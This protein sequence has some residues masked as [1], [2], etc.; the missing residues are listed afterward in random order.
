MVYFFMQ[1]LHPKVSSVKM[2]DTVAI[3]PIINLNLNS[4]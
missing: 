3:Y 2:A 4:I 1:G